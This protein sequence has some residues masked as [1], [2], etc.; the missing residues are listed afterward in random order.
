MESKKIQHG[1]MVASPLCPIPR[2]SARLSPAAGFAVFFALSVVGNAALGQ[3]ASKMFRWVDENGDVH[4]T[5]QIPPN[6]AER[7][8]ATISN[9]GSRLEAV[10]PAKSVEE[11]QREAELERQRAQQAVLLEQQKAADAQLLR[12]YRSVDD[13]LMARDGKVAQLD[14]VIQMA[15]S[16]IRRQQEWL[17]KLRSEAA[18]LERGGKPVPQQLTD[19]LGKGERT[20][21]EAYATIVDREQEKAAIRQEFG[22]DLKRYRQ[23]KGLPEDTAAA[24]PDSS[25]LALRNLVTCQ[26]SAQCD[27][28]WGRAL[29]YVQAH[30]TTQIQ[31]TSATIVMTAPPQT[32]EDLGFSL[33]RIPD[34]EGSAASIFLDLQCKN[35]NPTNTGCS[36]ANA[37]ATKVL[38]EFRDVVIG[39]Q[40]G[41]APTAGVPPGPAPR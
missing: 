37:N 35:P 25:R 30:A 8:H 17:R 27:L 4:Y 12:T 36:T 39:A 6:Q 41:S 32:P 20:I 31:T 5:D 10:A 40:V 29:T 21:R 1:R 19:S 26:D 34:K 18:D 22:G 11:L 9:Q 15:R 23:L 7:G 33:S 16:T 14:A 24:S 13:L 2:R 38:N 3:A 28:Y